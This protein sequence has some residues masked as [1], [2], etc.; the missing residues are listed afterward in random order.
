MIGFKPVGRLRGESFSKIAELVSMD[1]SKNVD[2]LLSNSDWC[3]DVWEKLFGMNQLS[4]QDHLDVIYC[5]II[6]RRKGRNKTK[7]RIKRRYKNSNVCSDISR[8]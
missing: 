4:R 5:S 7:I 3:S 6:E 8:W 1:D 2:T